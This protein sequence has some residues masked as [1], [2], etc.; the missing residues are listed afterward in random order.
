LLIS[1]LPAAALEAQSSP[2]AAPESASAEPIAAPAARP[3]WTRLVLHGGASLAANALSSALVTGVAFA[4]IPWETTRASEFLQS[5]K[6]LVASTVVG[7]SVVSL[8]SSATVTWLARRAGATPPFVRVW[9]ASALVA[10]SFG[11]AALLLGSVPLGVVGWLA[12]A[13]AEVA[14]ADVVYAPSER[15]VPREQGVLRPIAW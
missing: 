13:A 15:A 10:V 8:G 11:V 5:R 4:A 7:L 14:V 1:A 2:A 3:P 9:L 6:R 12:T